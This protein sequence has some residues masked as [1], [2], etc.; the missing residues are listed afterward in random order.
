MR[1][2]DEGAPG[3]K[4]IRDM[5]VE[6]RKSQEARENPDT[7]GSIQIVVEQLQHS[8]DEYNSV[9]WQSVLDSKFV[10]LFAGESLLKC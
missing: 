4:Q 5:L 3:L 1:A 10:E 7:K 6:A 9:N 2:G 8:F